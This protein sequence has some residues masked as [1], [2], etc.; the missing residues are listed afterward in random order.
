M[1]A[2]SPS[3][4]LMLCVILLAIMVVAI[5]LVVPSGSVGVGSID[6]SSAK[7]PV[8]SSSPPC[9]SANGCQ[10]RNVSGYHLFDHRMSADGATYP[11]ESS[12][13]ENVLE[14][15]LSEAGASPSHL[16]LRGTAKGNSARC[17]FRGISRTLGQRERTIRFWLELDEDDTLPSP[18]DVER[19]FMSHLDRIN[20]AFPETAKASFRSI[21]RGGF[22]TDYMFL[23]C[24]MDYTVAEYLLGSGPVTVTVAYDQ[25]AEARSYDLY[26]R[27][28]AAGEFGDVETTTKMS[29]G[30]YL[31]SLDAIVA[32]NEG[33]LSNLLGDRENIVFV[34]PMGAHSAITLEAWQVIAQWDLQT[35][36]DNT[37]HAVRY[38]SP[39]EDPEHTQTLANLKSRITTAAASD[40]HANDRIANVSGL[41]Q[42]YKDVGAYG[43]ITPDDGSTETFT[44]AQPPPVPECSNDTAVT[45]ASVNRSLVHDCG[46]LLGL[47]DTLAGTAT[48]NWSSDLAIGSWTG[49][50]TGGTPQRV[51]GLSLPSNSLNGTMPAELGTL[52]SLTTL[53]LRS[54]SFTGNIPQELGHLP[55]LATLRLSGNSLSGCIPAA[56]RNVAT[57]DLASLTLLYCDMLPMPTAPA[58]LSVSLEDGT[59]ALT[60]DALS[61]AAKYE[62]QYRTSDAEDWTALPEVETNSATYAPEGGPACGTTYQ[63]RVRA[64]GDGMTLRAE[65][66]TESG[67]ETYET[68]ACNQA[69][70]FDPDSYAFTVP[71]D[72][73]V[74]DLVDTVS[75]TDPDEDDTVSYSIT[76]GNEEGKFAIG[77][78]SGEITV[79]AALDYETT[80]SFTLTVQAGDGN[81]GTDTATVEITVTD[82]AE[83][84]VPAPTGLAVS[85]ADGA[86]T[87]TWDTVAGASKYEAQH[88]SSDTGDW[89][90]LPG[91]ETTTATYTPEGGPA[92]GT[93][94]QFR[95]R[96]HGDAVTYADDWGPESGVETHETEACNAAPEFDSESY[97]FTVDETA[98]TGRLVGTV[99]APDADEG[100]AVAYTITGGN[101]DGKFSLDEETGE[102]TLAD[103]L[104]QTLVSAYTL[105]V[106]AED[107]NGGESAATVSI[108]VGSVCRNGTVIPNP[109]DNADLISDCLILY[110]AKGTLEGTAILDWDGDTALADW[111][112]VTVQARRILGLELENMALDGTVP[113]TLGEI[114]NLRRLDLSGNGLSGTIPVKLGDLS[115]LKY[116]DLRNNS[117]E[118]DIPSALGTLSILE[119]LYL[120]DNGLTGTIPTELGNLLRLDRLN[121]KDNQLTGSIPAS[122]GN[123]RLM[124]DLR[125]LGNQLNGAIPSQLGNLSV[126]ESLYLSDNQ[127]DGEIPEELGD[128][129]ELRVLRLEVNR[130]SGEI[131]EELAN[132]SALTQMLLA[133]NDLTGTIPGEL[134]DMPALLE[135][136]VAGNRLSGTI[137]LSLARLELTDLFLS[138]NS[139]TG[140]LPHGLRDVDWNDHQLDPVAVMPDCDNAAPAF[141]EESYAFSVPEDAANGDRVG[142]VAAEDPDGRTVTYTITAGNDAGKFGID[143]TSGRLSVAGELD[144]ETTSSYSLTVRASDSENATSEVTVTIGVSDVEE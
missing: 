134:G 1:L 42:Y 34:A 16:V 21:A 96:S 27:A 5:L 118:G 110:G 22:S 6:D 136:W 48:L 90:A 84:M 137:P 69:P 66:S 23:T 124:E 15:G 43:D 60:W 71:E 19:Q 36:D 114:S 8:L 94:Y 14:K 127:L 64:F 77:E 100:D 102:V 26:D 92:C 24:F 73:A 140:C 17:E 54:N 139:F 97:G 98:P 125:L 50:T 62:A 20:V 52:W 33:L 12:T 93:I 63:F 11:I 35:D 31:A 112:G 79:E 133:D 103:T 138:E 81:G 132:L 108:T 47:K 29:R 123:L 56:L 130:L 41:T 7:G 80:A 113:P 135:L 111:P 83:D 144:H 101:E 131:P 117:L 30:E 51:T 13:V 75:A 3:G 68:E 88:R 55:E 78:T 85:L 129:S 53:D 58:N 126:L 32:A 91:V 61:G 38:G 141:A 89:T 70:D 122:L 106:R 59:F 107:G 57:N 25:L 72:A 40:A 115:L 18:E 128:L 49:V 121:L 109:G 2:H 67:A 104:D 10:P 65:W 45:D 120:H 143:S 37:V 28:H 74:D 46:T 99:A 105:S 4:R 86:F 76:A 95:V 82:V 119:R 87:L 116:L 44:P 9:P 39:D 142:R